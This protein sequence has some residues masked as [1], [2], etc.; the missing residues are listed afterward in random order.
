MTAKKEHPCREWKP[1]RPAR[2]LVT[3]LAE[4]PWIL[5]DT[6]Y[7][8]LEQ[9]NE[10]LCNVFETKLS[11]ENEVLLDQPLQ[12]AEYSHRSCPG[13]GGMHFSI[14]GLYLYDGTR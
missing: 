8:Q 14:P 13:G 10:W 2:S 6:M 11:E 3:I 7:A 12:I 4:L 9:R 5:L 1:G